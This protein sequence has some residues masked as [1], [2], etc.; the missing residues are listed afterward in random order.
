MNADAQDIALYPPLAPDGETVAPAS[1]KFAAGCLSMMKDQVAGKILGTQLVSENS[2]W[3]T[4]L[5]ID[6]DTPD[7]DP[8]GRVNRIMCWRDANGRYSIMFAVAQSV[9]PLQPPR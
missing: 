5:R 2:R 1:S 7:F 4:V 6:F 9:P 3:G 8:R